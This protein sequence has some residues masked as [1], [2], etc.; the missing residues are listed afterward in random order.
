[1]N[2][3]VG[4]FFYFI[5]CSYKFNPTLKNNIKSKRFVNDIGGGSKERDF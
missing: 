1:M 2:L 4:Y 3:D 5:F